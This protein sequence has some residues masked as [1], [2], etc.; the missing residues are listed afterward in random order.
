MKWLWVLLLVV[1]AFLLAIVGVVASADPEGR[2]GK[3]AA[4]LFGTALVA[5]SSAISLGSVFLRMP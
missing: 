4:V 2:G 1:V 3:V 5:L